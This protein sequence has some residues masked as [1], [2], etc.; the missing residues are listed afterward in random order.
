MPTSAQRT[1]RFLSTPSARRATAH[2]DL[3]GAGLGFL[4]TPSARRATVVVD[5]RLTGQGISIH[6]L[7]EEGDGAAVMAAA[8]N[9]Y[10]YPRPPR[11]GRQKAKIMAASILEISIHALREEGDSAGPL[12][13]RGL[14]I[15]I[16]AL[17][18]EGDAGLGFQQLLRDISIHALREEGDLPRPTIRTQAVAFLSTPSA[19][20]ATG[21]DAVSISGLDRIS[22][23]ALRE[24]GDRPAQGGSRQIG[25]SIHALREEGDSTATM[26]R[27]TRTDFYPRP[28]RGGRHF[29]MVAHISN[30]GFLSTPSARRATFLFGGLASGAK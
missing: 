18:E 17:R 13:G 30:E 8:V 19:R 12:F 28:P 24:E 9:S 20:R 25:I 21:Q 11:G 23:H 3:L 2:V 29:K 14:P 7:R 16:H 22:I 4:S 1:M 5:E 10:F 6:A 27:R 15:S 26:P